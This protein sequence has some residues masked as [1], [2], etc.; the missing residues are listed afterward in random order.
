LHQE[1][2]MESVTPT[3]ESTMMVS[4]TSLIEFN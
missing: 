4:T 3:V 2:P 1:K